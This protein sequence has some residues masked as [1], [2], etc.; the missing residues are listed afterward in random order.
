MGNHPS[1]TLIDVHQSQ[2]LNHTEF[3]EIEPQ[4]SLWD[5][6]PSELIRLILS[7]LQAKEVLKLSAVS[8]RFNCEINNDLLWQTIWQNRSNFACN[9]KL[10]RGK[11]TYKQLFIKFEKLQSGYSK[12]NTTPHKSWKNVLSW[13]M[14][15]SDK[16]RI[17]IT[18]LNFSGRRTF[19]YYLTSL[20]EEKSPLSSTIS[21]HDDSQGVD[22]MNIT[23]FKFDIMT[24]REMRRSYGI[25]FRHM[26]QGIIYFLD[27]ADI[28]RLTENAKQFH[29][30]LQ[31][32]HSDSVPVVVFA[33]KQD[34]ASAISV[35]EVVSL[36]Q[37]EKE[38]RPWMCIGN[39]FFVQYGDLTPLVKGCKWLL[40][41]MNL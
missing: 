17:G 25:S 19:L 34:K 3:M 22:V 16:P 37:L 31:M 21:S 5:L 12:T 13:N 27:C 18:G 11:H 4:H 23:W 26:V 40:N 39:S 15:F 9:T 28:R 29:R 7:H 33:N 41:Q 14:L 36:L 32:L 10:S 6:L 20:V 30:A 38:K 35:E 2:L 1:T 8:R 24:D